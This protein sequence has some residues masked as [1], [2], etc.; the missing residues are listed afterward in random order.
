MNLTAKPK[1]RKKTI[2]I[3]LFGKGGTNHLHRQEIIDEF[4]KNE[5]KERN[6]SSGSVACWM[7]ALLKDWF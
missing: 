3:P 7:A 1:D 6:W 5:R 2:G 4:A